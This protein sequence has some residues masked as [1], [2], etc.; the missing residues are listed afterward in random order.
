MPDPVLFSELLGNLI[1]TAAEAVKGE[2]SRVA[3]FGECVDLLWARGNASAAIQ[4]EKFGNQLAKRYNADILRGY[5]LD[6]F[7]GGMDSHI[8]QQICAEHLAVRS[9]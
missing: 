4:M 6:N 8:F 2:Q 1:V 7:N 3:I 9:R 5:S